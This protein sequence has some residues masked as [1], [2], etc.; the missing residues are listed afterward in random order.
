MAFDLHFLA[1]NFTFE[2]TYFHL[3]LGVVLL[4]IIVS[5]IYK[6]PGHIPSLFIC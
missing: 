4:T 1:F 5:D 3:A 6:Q 2:Q